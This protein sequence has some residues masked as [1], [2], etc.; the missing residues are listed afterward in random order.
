[1]VALEASGIPVIGAP[2]AEAAREL[3][4]GQKPDLILMDIQ[5]PGIDG[6]ELT[7]EL[8]SNPETAAIQVVALTAHSMPIYE[9]AARAAGCI[10]YMVKPASPAVLVALVRGF[11]DDLDG[12]PR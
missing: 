5:L 11:L 1:M 6:L 10:G 12:D 2:S 7:R 3:I 8:K 9:R 4:S